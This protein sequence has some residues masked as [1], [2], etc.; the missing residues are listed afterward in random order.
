MSRSGSRADH[1]RFCKI[2]GRVEVRNARGKAVGH[3]IT[4]ELSLSDGRILRSRISRPAD[5]T[6]Y[7]IGLWKAI[8]RDQLCVSEEEFWACVTDR[9]PPD[10]GVQAASVPQRALPASLAAQLI[11]EAGIPESRVAQMTL[12]EAV[13]AMTEHWSKPKR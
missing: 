13:A 11:R 12:E 1:H 4:Y 6:A 3:H 2:E 8:L 7:G 5:G 10:R 9:K